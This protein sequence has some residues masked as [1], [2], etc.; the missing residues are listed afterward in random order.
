MFSAHLKLVLFL[1][2]PTHRHKSKKH[3]DLSEI[4]LRTPTR[5]ENC[6]MFCTVKEQQQ[7]LDV[8]DVF[9]LW[10]FFNMQTRRA[11]R[12]YELTERQ[13]PPAARPGPPGTQSHTQ[14]L[15]GLQWVCHQSGT[16]Q[17]YINHREHYV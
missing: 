16:D 12:R 5:R 17:V 10:F 4:L 9:C 7:Q 6:V 2:S 13:H 14:Q 3:S 11:D 1:A 8:N 15:S